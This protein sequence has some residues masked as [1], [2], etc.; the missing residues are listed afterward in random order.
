MC[1]LVL[2]YL[3]EEHDDIV[4]EKVV[5]EMTKI[6]TMSLAKQV[7]LRSIHT[8]KIL[9]PVAGRG[10]HDHLLARFLGS[11]TRE[12][13]CHVTFMHVANPGEGQ[14]QRG[15]IERQLSRLADD[16]LRGQSEVLV[17]ESGDPV[18]R[19]ARELEQYDLTILGMQRDSSGLRVLSDFM[20]TLAGKTANPLVVIS[21]KRSNSSNVS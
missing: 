8:R 19:I 2:I 12:K 15:R 7:R 10:G 5:R 17:V 14:K 6:V 11:L 18:E 13:Q 4:I 16:I 3:L 1:S 20:R 21:S 9:V